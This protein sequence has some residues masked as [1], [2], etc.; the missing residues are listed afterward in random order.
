M[1]E[2]VRVIRIGGGGGGGG[3]GGR[4]S[5]VA[6]WIARSVALAA[7]T[8]LGVVMF[9]FL[10][11]IVLVGLVVALVAGMGL[12]IRSWFRRQTAPNGMLDGRR[13]VRVVRGGPTQEVDDV[14]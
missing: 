5:V 12:W 6:T 9:V 3:G 8:V 11:G 4:G 14:R 13:N 10:S 1:I 2:H 7:A